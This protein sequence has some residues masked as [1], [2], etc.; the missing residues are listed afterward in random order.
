[1][2]GHYHAEFF[3]YVGIKV[4]GCKLG[5]DCYQDDR[6]YKHSIN[7]LGVKAHPSLDAG[8]ESTG[9]LVAYT[10]DQTYFKYLDPELRQS[11]NIFF[12]QSSIITN[13]NI[14]DIFKT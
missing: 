4:T 8:A 3:N 14:F 10:P 6:L 11:T 7:F 12:M 2:R 9:D 13:D 5:S 1:M